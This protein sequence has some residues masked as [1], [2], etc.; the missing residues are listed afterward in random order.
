MVW[1]V[2]CRRTGLAPTDAW[3]PPHQAPEDDQWLITEWMDNLLQIRSEMWWKSFQEE[4]KLIQLQKKGQFHIKV[5]VVES[6]IVTVW[7]NSQVSD[8]LCPLSVAV[9]KPMDGWMD[10]LTHSRLMPTINIPSMEQSH[11][12]THKH[13]FSYFQL[14]IY[15]KPVESRLNRT[16]ESTFQKR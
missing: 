11:L 10:V 14:L 1:W 5:Y 9:N 4:L 13:L 16:Q 7:C 3:L 8:N 2:W 6:N 12:G 15:Q